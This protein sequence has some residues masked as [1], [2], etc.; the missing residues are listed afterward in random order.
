[1]D[2]QANTS[3]LVSEPGNYF[4]AEALEASKN[5]R[6]KLIMSHNWE[7]INIVLLQLIRVLKKNTQR[8]WRCYDDIRESRFNKAIECASNR[9]KFLKNDVIGSAYDEIPEENFYLG[10]QQ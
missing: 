9:G 6:Y 8:Y 3:I 5:L 7:N 10:I 4:D 2:Q 1:M